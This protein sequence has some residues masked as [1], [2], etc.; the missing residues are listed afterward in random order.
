MTWDWA[1]LVDEEGMKTFVDIS[2]PR[3]QIIPEWVEV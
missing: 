1:V 3:K 2:I